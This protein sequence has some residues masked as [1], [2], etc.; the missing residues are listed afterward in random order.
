MPR[1]AQKN[2]NNVEQ[3]RKRHKIAEEMQE[4]SKKFKMGGKTD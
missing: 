4:N 2:Q 3:M 1:K